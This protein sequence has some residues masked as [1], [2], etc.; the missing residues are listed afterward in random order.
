MLPYLSRLPPP[1]TPSC[2][3][4]LLEQPWFINLEMTKAFKIEKYPR[5][6]IS[7]LIKFDAWG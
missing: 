3:N 7:E 2:C 4:A 1:S 5:Y 6:K